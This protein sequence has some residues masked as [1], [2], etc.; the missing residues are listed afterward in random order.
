MTRKD[1]SIAV[2]TSEPLRDLGL[3]ELCHAYHTTPDFILELISYGTIE[4]QGN[5]IATWRFDSH[6]LQVVR[7]AVHLHHDLEVNHAGIALAIDL[8]EQIESLQ[9][10]LN[11]LNKYF[12]PDISS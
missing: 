1:H 7:T 6:Q 5:S 12:N 4:P 10:E 3:E 8:L 2:K 9:N 11:V